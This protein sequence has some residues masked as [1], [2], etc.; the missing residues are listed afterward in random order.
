MVMNAHCK[1][2]YTVYTDQWPL[3]WHFV[4]DSRIEP[5]AK[6]QRRECPKCGCA[7]LITYPEKRS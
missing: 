1:R 4:T 3:V 5:V 7:V 6:A 2:C